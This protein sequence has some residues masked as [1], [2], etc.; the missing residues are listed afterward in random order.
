MSIRKSKRIRWLVLALIAALLLWIGVDLFFP[1][2]V[3]IRRFNAEEVARLDTAMWRS[4]YDRQSRRLFF[5]LAELMR[6]QFHFPI[7]RSN[8]VALSAARAA[9]IFKDGHNR[10]DY[11]KALPDLV[12]YFQQIRDISAT[13]FDVQRTAELELEWWIVHRERDTHHE[14]DLARAIAE[15]AAE[16]YQVPVDKLTE[17][18]HYRAA[19]MTIRDTKAAAGGVTEDDWHEIQTDLLIAWQSLWKA[20]QTS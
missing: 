6:D 16:L 8:R 17:Y 4:Y 11:E 10:P 7:F 15:A 12:D 3:D 13:S 20:V 2:R 18:G 14:G 1:R 5:Q 19:A 9:F